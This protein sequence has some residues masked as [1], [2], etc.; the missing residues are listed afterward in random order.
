MIMQ[1]SPDVVAN[2]DPAYLDAQVQPDVFA[3]EFGDGFEP[4]LEANA[5]MQL[6]DA[7]PE[8]QPELVYDP[9]APTFNRDLLDLFF[10]SGH[11]PEFSK[12]LAS[13]LVTDLAIRT[14][15]YYD[16]GLAAEQD[17]DDLMQWS[18]HEEEKKKEK[19][20]V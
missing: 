20:L 4:S 11:N 12:A 5:S 8:V 7:M 6:M 17:Y 15:V 2:F 14:A 1:K 13:F 10:R 18:R 16:P 3:V 9:N 19:V